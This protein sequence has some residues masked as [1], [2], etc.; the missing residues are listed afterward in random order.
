MRRL[1]TSARK[2]RGGAVEVLAEEEVEAGELKGGRKVS[3]V[4]ADVGVGVAECAIFASVSLQ[5]LVLRTSRD[6]VSRKRMRR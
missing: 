3:G 6:S 5:L 4:A 2:G 1:I